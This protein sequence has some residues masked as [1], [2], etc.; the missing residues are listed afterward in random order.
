[1]GKSRLPLEQRIFIPRKHPS[2]IITGD[3]GAIPGPF[4]V[5]CGNE[6]G[7][8]RDSDGA[9]PVRRLHPSLPPG[10]REKCNCGTRVQ[11][12]H[13]PECNSRYYGFNGTVTR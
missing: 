8:H 3:L 10:E 9:C 12:R 11:S 7:I 1:M 13:K 5:N 4:C 2:V 6:F